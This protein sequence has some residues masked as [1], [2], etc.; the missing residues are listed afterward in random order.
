MQHSGDYLLTVKFTGHR[1][2]LKHIICDHKVEIEAERHR[3]IQGTLKIQ[4]EMAL[5]NV[6][7]E[8]ENE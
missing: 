7:E 6:T 8:I 5:M 3:E 1:E 2:T 4:R